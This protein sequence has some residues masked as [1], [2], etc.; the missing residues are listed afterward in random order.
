MGILP[1]PFPFKFNMNKVF[2]QLITNLLLLVS[3]HSQY[4][5]KLISNPTDQ[6]INSVI[7]D[8]NGN[9][10]LAGR[11]EK[12]QGI[13]EGYLIKIDSLG[14]LLNELTLISD[15]NS[16]VIFNLH[17]SAAT[18]L[19]IGEKF[20]KT[21]M[22]F[23]NCKLW[24]LKLNNDL[25]VVDEKFCNVKENNWISYMNSI[26]DSDSNIVIAGYTSRLDTISNNYNFDT[27]LYKISN[28]GDSINSKFNTTEHPHDL[29]F[30]IIEKPEKNGYFAFFSHYSEIFGTNGQLLTLDENLDSLDIDSIPLGIY[31]YYS[32]IYLIDSSILLYGKRGGYNYGHDLN[33]ISIS[34]DNGLIN[35]E[36]FGKTDTVDWPA[37]S[38][39]ISR[40][41]ENIFVA[42]TSNLDISNPFFSS[43][44][45]WFYLINLNEDLT[46][47]WQ[48]WYGGDAYYHLCSI[49][50][51]KDGGCILVGTRY[52]YQTQYF[53]RDVYILK[54]NQEG[55]ITWTYNFPETTRQVIVYPNPGR[56]EI[57]IKA[58][59]NNLRF[60]LFDINGNKIL[61]Q[62]IEKEHNINTSHL[63]KGV[64][65]YRILNQKSETI[66]TGKWIKD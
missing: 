24:Y 6:I 25:E 21:N 1:H 46:I 42:G 58:I 7:E 38:K 3:V 60:D 40:L 49:T 8:T 33:V 65:T 62:P 44:P 57:W 17:L 53:E 64:Y 41:Y 15:S 12:S 37:Y 48:K 30:D 16:F 11:I 4:F 13:Y 45:S 14:N 5:S 22:P 19:I 28:N 2:L 32:P 20:D 66:E 61:S 23:T 52:D 9:Y 47:N 10:I 35:F 55:I 29:C 18:Y 34:I 39:G 54:V 31:D 36:H 50:A 43:Q 63:Q 56:D 51:T 59:E 26:T 27:F